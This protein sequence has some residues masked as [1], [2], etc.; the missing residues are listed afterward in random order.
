MVAAMAEREQ[1][2]AAALGAGKAS[3]AARGDLEL[4]AR[5]NVK[6]PTR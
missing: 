4:E 2:L 6:A 1:G 3:R 5:G